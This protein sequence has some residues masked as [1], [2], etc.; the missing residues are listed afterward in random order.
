M[1]IEIVDSHTHWGP[2]VTIGTEVMTAN[3]SWE[4]ILFVKANGISFS[5][6][7]LGDPLI[8]PQMK[9]VKDSSP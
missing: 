3:F 4:R 7:E 1:A 5:Y 6:M 2:S 9:L 8:S